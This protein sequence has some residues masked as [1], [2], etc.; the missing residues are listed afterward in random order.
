M[1]PETGPVYAIV[2]IYHKGCAILIIANFS[3]QRAGAP[4]LVLLRFYVMLFFLF[5]EVD[6]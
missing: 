1:I 3:Y 5:S 2:K 6:I 4:L